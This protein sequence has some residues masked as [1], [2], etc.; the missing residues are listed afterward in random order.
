MSRHTKE[1][2][3]GTRK[4]TEWARPARDRRDYRVDPRWTRWCDHR[5]G[6]F[7]PESGRQPHTSEDGVAECYRQ[8]WRSVA[9]A[10][11]VPQ[12]PIWSPKEIQ[13]ASAFAAWALSDG[14]RCHGGGRNR[15]H[16]LLPVQF[17]PHRCHAQ[18]GRAAI[19]AQVR[20]SYAAAGATP[21]VWSS[22]GPRS[23]GASRPESSSEVG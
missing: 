8:R 14:L 15:T 13:A 19:Q 10:N 17:L 21:G 22:A 18:K 1:C 3:H 5:C 4:E 12:E 6:I 9:W 7:W 2:V 16:C 11:L 23:Q 20:G